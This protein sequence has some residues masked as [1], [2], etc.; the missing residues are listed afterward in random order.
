[1]VQPEKRINVGNCTASVFVN[2]VNSEKGSFQKRT[3]TLQK[4]YK[5]KEGKDQYTNSYD[6]NEL[7]KLK[8][9]ITKPLS[10]CFWIGRRGN[11]FSLFLLNLTWFIW[12]NKL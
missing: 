12:W 10:I 2:E 6:V 4:F 3:A 8:M 9:V 11:P 7:F 1:M 5:D